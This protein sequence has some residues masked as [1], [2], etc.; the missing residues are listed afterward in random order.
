ML[1]SEGL[2]GSASFGLAFGASLLA[3]WLLI[4]KLAVPLNARS[5]AMDTRAKQAMHR[6]P[7]PRTGGISILSALAV[8]LLISSHSIGSDLAWALAAA[9]VVFFVGLKEDIFRDV[10]P[11]TRLLAAFASAG[12]ALFMSSRMITRLDLPGEEDFLALGALWILV[13][14]IWSAGTCHA[15]NLIDGLN[16]LSS[17][18]VMIAVAAFGAVAAKAG[19]QDIVFVSSILIAAVLGFWVFNWPFGK[20]FLGDAGAYA[21]GHIVAWLGIVMIA[22]GP[23]VS[24]LAVLLILFWPVADTVFTVARRLIYRR[25]VGQPD[26]FHF[27]HIIV[28]VVARLNKGRLSV[29]SVNSLST[30][31][32]YPLMAGPAL[33]GVLF[34]NKPTH[35]LVALLVCLLVFLAFYSVTVDLLAAR[36]F[37]KV[38]RK[39]FA[40]VSSA[41]SSV[42]R[43]SLSGIFIDESLAVD[44]IIQR[45]SPD[46]EWTLQAVA[47]QAPGRVWPRTFSSDTEA[48]KAFMETVAK[49]GMEAIVGF[50]RPKGRDAYDGGFLH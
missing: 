46:D 10:S 33:L 26:R 35:S 20:I 43:S 42:E 12:I 19:H 11:K 23:E 30:L 4:T 6:V 21:L 17:G 40:H 13:T 31:V 44:V 48:W 50:A 9:S 28:R 49:E 47:D 5:F 32:M 25:S 2:A 34:W 27:H 16:G 3:T 14:L 39:V 24:P 8:V 15:L 38:R 7:T 36:K 41:V 37:R 18:Y 45:A 22:R 29:R 1:F